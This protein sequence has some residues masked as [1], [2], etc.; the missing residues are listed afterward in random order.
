MVPASC[1]LSLAD[2]SVRFQRIIE[3]PESEPAEEDLPPIDGG[4]SRCDIA[5]RVLVL[6]KMAQ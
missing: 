2:S 4:W 3:N 6:H 1:Q 5:K